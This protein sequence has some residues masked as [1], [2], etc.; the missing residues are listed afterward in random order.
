MN[1]KNK[2]SSNDLQLLSC[3][4][5]H[6]NL[7]SRVSRVADLLDDITVT[8]LLLMDDKATALQIGRLRTLLEKADQLAEKISSQIDDKRYQ[9]SKKYW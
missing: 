3:P 2:L 8:D 4:F 7:A 1:K 5:E 9:D 6:N